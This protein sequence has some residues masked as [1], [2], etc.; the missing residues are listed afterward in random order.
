MPNRGPPKIGR[1][2]AQKRKR[3]FPSEIDPNFAWSA[4]FRGQS[5]FKAESFWVS[6]SG[7]IGAI[8]PRQIPHGSGTAGSGTTMVGKFRDGRLRVA[9]G[10]ATVV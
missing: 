1:K 8:G 7:R 2:T 10:G 9:P 4:P 5:V 6:L 3:G